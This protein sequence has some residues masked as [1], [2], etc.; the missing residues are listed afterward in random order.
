M[1]P[2]VQ[3]IIESAV[4]SILTALG[5]YLAAKGFPQSAV[6][7]VPTLAPGLATIV[8]GIVVALAPFAHTLVDKWVKRR[9]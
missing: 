1:N 7:A 8:L 9:R 6:D 4:K 3:K 2:I 5:T